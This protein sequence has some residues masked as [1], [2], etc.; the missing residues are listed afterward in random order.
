MTTFATGASRNLD[1]NKLDFDGFY[2]PWVIEAYARYMHK[3]RKQADGTFRGSDNW[4]QGIP[5]KSY[6][7][8]LW[9][10]FFAVWFGLITGTC[11][12]DDL[13]GILFNTMGIMHEF[14]VRPETQTQEVQ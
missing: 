14:H 8:S 6:K 5:L 13:C 3:N 10:H 12:M 2:S 11:S 9:R 4:K 1:E 7:K